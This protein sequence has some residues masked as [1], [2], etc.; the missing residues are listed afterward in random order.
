[1]KNIF[2]TL[3]L[4]LLT[5]P[6]LLFSQNNETYELSYNVHLSYPPGSISKQKLNEAQTL[7]DLDKFYR[8]SWVRKYISVEL[9]ASH[10]G[11]IVKAMGKNDTLTQAQK[12]I[13]KKADPGTNISVK[14]HYIPENTLKQ[15]APKEFNFTLTVDPETEAK[16][17]GRQQQL[18]QYLKVNLI[19]KI[20]NYS[21]RQYQLA[22]VKFTIDEKGHVTEPHIFWTS[23]DEKTDKLLLETVCNMP[24]WN[25]AAY[26]NG[27]KVKQ[28]FVLT[29]GDM[30]SCVVNLL[31][32]RRD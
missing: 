32:I 10:N 20:A 13:I 29:V 9:L 17:P 7:T 6:I 25:P 22:V 4:L 30:E 8:P 2:A 24:N 23:E 18:K 27:T 14:V 21:F 31:N 11:K 15:N 19:D 26:A 16:Y 3:P 28:D 1:M 5:F 12:D